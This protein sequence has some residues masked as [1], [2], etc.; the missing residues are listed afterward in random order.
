MSRLCIN[1]KKLKNT[2]MEKKIASVRASVIASG[3][4]ILLLV[5]MAVPVKIGFRRID[6]YEVTKIEKVYKGTDDV[7][8][9]VFTDK[10]V[11]LIELSGLNAYPYGIQVI[12][13]LGTFTMETRG[14][15]MEMYG[16]YPN[17]V[18]VIEDE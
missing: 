7:R 6:T 9:F 10:G 4:A 11:L 2:N 16:M 18:N 13:E 1:G 3:V 17:I 5:A 15:R 14:V 8:Y 12:K